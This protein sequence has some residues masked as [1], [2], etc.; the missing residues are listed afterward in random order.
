MNQIPLIYRYR[1]ERRPEGYHF[2]FPDLNEAD[3]TAE[4]AEDGVRDAPDHLARALVARIH[5]KNPPVTERAHK[6]EGIAQIPSSLAAR[7]LFIARSEEVGMYP[8]ELARRLNMKPQEVHRIYR[9]EHAT[10]I[11]TINM[12]LNA[13]GS[14]IALT[15]EPLEGDSS[16]KS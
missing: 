4:T 12:A 8:A 11:D 7:I 3:F 15:V 6:G 1:I 10:K 2:R 9:L 5:E 14:R 13:V 16:K